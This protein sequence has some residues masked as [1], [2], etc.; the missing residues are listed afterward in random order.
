M[1]WAVSM[2]LRLNRRASNNSEGFTLIEVLIMSPIIM[3]TIIITLSYLFN[4]YGQLTQQGSQINLNL[5]AQNI[6]FGMQDDVYYANSFVSGINSGL[7][8]ANQPSGGWKSST[9]NTLIISTPAL[10]DNYRSDSRQPVYIN[11]YGCTSAVIENNSFLYNNNIYFASGTTLYKRIITAPSSMPTCGTSFLKQ[12]CPDSN[13]TSTCQ[14]DIIL[15]NYLN[16]LVLTYYD[17][18][19]AVV[20]TPELATKIKI[21]LQLKDRAYANDIYANSSITLKKLN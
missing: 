11:S 19:G 1:D 12:T 15:S 5:E 8:D 17:S 16:S 4:L 10:T 2:K 13:A 20:S 18:A 3:V 7:I 6:V 14:P 21:D 9:P